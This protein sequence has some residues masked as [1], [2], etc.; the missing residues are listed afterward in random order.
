MKKIISAILRF[1]KDVH[2]P[3]EPR[4][5]DRLEPKKEKLNNEE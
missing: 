1:K 5:R 2:S 3:E 4:K